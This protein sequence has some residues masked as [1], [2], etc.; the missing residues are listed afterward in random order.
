[1]FIYLKVSEME[2]LQWTKDIHSPAVYS[3][4]FNQELQSMW[5]EPSNLSQQS[6]ATSWQHF[7]KFTTE[8]LLLKLSFDF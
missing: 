1:M 8:L 6:Q 7:I 5:Q 4:E 2:K 3:P